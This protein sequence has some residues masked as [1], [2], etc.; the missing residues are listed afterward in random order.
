MI[1]SYDLNPDDMIFSD[2]HRVVHGRTTFEDH[3]DPDLKR[4][5]LRT[6]IK[7]KTYRN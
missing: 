2:N 6:W 7:D 5:M 1:L 3:N 4:L